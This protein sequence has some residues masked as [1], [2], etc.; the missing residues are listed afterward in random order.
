MLH[1]SPHAEQ[2]QLRVHAARQY[3]LQLLIFEG[4]A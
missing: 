1:V 2:L 4:S 3:H